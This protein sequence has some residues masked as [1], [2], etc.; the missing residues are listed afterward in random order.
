MKPN[1]Q[2][3]F[4]MKSCPNCHNQAKDDA[5]FCPVCGTTLDAIV[6][7]DA[8]YFK[9]EPVPQPMTAYVPPVPAPQLHDHTSDFFSDDIRFSKLVCMVV[10]LLDFIGII[11]AL[12]MAGSSEY[13]QFHI[14]QSL[15][16]TVL[17]T[18]ISLVSLLLCWTFIVPIVGVIALVVLIAIK[19]VCFVDVCNGKAKDAPIIRSIRFLN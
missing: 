13:T 17:E 14:R 6:Q 10:Y 9:Q 18:L 4:S 8:E 12:L 1:F 3:E 19:F 7:P 11:I 15:K 16:F 2:E 5:L